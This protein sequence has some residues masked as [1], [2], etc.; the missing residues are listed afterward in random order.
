MC[1]ICHRSPCHPR[2]PNASDPPVV[3]LCTNCGHEIYDGD[4]GYYVNDEWWCE[5]CMRG[6]FRIAEADFD[7]YD[8]YE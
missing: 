3:G 8:G 4:D 2:C 5:D 7:D 6:C 1:E